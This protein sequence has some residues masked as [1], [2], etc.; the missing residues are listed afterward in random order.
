ALGEKIVGS[1]E[2]FVF[3]MNE[4]AAQLGMNNTVY[5]DCTGMSEKTVSTAGDLALLS[6]EI[7][8]YDFLTPYFTTW[9]DYVRNQQTELVSTN[10]MIRTYKG[11][12]GLKSCAS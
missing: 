8:K 2:E 10:R 5:A 6:C 4:R 1:E 12:T 11:V 3:L 9:I 7:L